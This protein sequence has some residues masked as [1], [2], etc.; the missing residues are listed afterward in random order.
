MLETQDIQKISEVVEE[1]LGTLKE[2]LL[3]PTLGEFTEDILL[4][5]VGTLLDEKNGTLRSDLIDYVSRTVSIEI[6]SL[7]CEL[8]KFK[9]EIVSAFSAYR[10]RDRLFKQQMLVILE[11]NKLARPE[12]VQ[13]LYELIA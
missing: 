7:R 10:E 11:R 8:L 6:A 4:P 5:A 1:K 12:E 2:H 3:L 9:D 13:V